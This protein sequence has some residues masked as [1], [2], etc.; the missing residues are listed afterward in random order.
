M[1]RLRQ[2]VVAARDL[3]ETVDR[4]CSVLG[5]RVCFNDPSVAEFGLH[6]ALLTVGDQFIEVVSP[7]V[8][9]TAAARLLDRRQ[10][11]VTAYMVMF[12]VD[13][14]DSRMA[15]LDGAG[16]R[17]VWSGDLPRIRGRHLHPGDMGG[18][19]V[20]LDETDPP[21]SWHWAGPN[22]TAHADNSVVSAIA[23]YTIGT[24]EPAIV[25]ARW[26]SAG[27][28]SGMGFVEGTS[29]E[30]DLVATDRRA[31]GRT[32]TLDQVVLRLV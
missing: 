27:L 22:W 30:I 32:V 25:E 13:D 31:V 7:I 10:A 19:I 2:V 21:G 26:T 1:I 11:I 20:S 6:N 9:G 12:E 8:D 3:E 24:D 14:L 4:L 17:T 23:G 28:T 29:S 18:A 16:V 5:L 15:A